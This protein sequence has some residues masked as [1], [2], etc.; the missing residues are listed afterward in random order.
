M[1]YFAYR[2]WRVIY[3]ADSIGQSSSARKRTLLLSCALMLLYI[4]YD[5]CFIIVFIKLAMDLSVVDC[6]Q[7]LFDEA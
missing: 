2:A 7:V 1:L 4:A 6:L 3:Q 5:F